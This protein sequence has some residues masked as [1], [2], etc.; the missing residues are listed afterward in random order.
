M[1]G[2]H[3]LLLLQGGAEFFPALVDAMDTARAVVH[4]ETYIFEF[5]GSA[6]SV[7]EAL[8]RAARRGVVVRLLIDGVGTPHVPDEWKQRFA[9][10][11]VT[12]RIYAPLGRLGLLL[13]R[14]WRRL[15]RKLCVV[16][17]VVGFCGGINIIDDQDDVALGRLAAPRLDF[18]L[19]V[20]GPLVEH[21]V[22]TMEQLWWRVL[23]A[24][25]AR[26]REFKAAWDA[27][28]QARPVGDFSRLLQKIESGLDP[29]APADS[30]FG[31]SAPS[32]LG[33]DGAR[34]RLLLRDNVSHRHDIERAYLKAIGEARQEIVIANA[35][36]I[37]GRK[38]RRALTLAAQRGV[39]VRLLLQG[40]YEHFL[41]YRAAR[42]V[43]QRLVDAGIQIHEYA[44]SALHAKVAVVDRRW[45]TV[46]STNLD[47][48]SMLLAREANVMTT[49]RRFSGL[50]HSHLDGL[51][52]QAGTLLDT[53][54]LG[55]R[56]WL[57]RQLDRVAF[58][59]MRTIL[60]VT[61]H[62]Y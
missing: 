45:S 20:A 42:P 52:Q 31:E 9:E 34:A 54:A 58:A 49:D 43:Y 25:R 57:Q 23:A 48:L 14:N 33:V 7:A 16:D 24:R 19:R 47:P 6:L 35:Y 50:L 51:V 22:D 60:F 29:D 61:G 5:A 36:F 55:Q 62:R 12:L 46:G 11:G 17:G 39:R 8:E 18:A 44:P 4:L 30:R 59:V 21:M 15:H 2:G 41:Q 40:R 32:P 37:P 3:Q 1:Q 13:P 26:Q 28:R 56:P 27:L 38:L 53:D 10:A